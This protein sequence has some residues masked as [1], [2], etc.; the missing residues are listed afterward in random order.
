L[1]YFC[2]SSCY[3][4]II[5]NIRAT[6]TLFQTG[7]GGRRKPVHTGYR[8]SFAF[9]TEKHYSGEIRLIDKKELS[10]GETGKANIKLLPAR[11][12]RK[13]LKPTDS[14]TITEGNKPI[15]MGVIEKVVKK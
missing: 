9:N 4:T 10:L 8:P 12:I 3:R 7:D 13:N 6:I 5:Y 14:F 2:G 15:G 11:T 1:R